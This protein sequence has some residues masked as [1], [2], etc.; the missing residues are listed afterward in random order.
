MVVQVEALLQLVG[1]LAADFLELVHDQSLA[2][3]GDVVAT[4]I[5]GWDNGLRKEVGLRRA[6]LTATLAV[7]SC[8]A[9]VTSLPAAG[10]H[11]AQRQVSQ[12]TFLGQPAWSPDGKHIAWVAGPPNG[13]GTVW[14]ADASGRNARPL[15]Q[16][17]QSLLG[18]DLVD[19]ITW[20]TSRSLLV[21]AEL[22]QQPLAL[23]RLS[24]SGRITRIAIVP[25][26]GFS[27]DRSRRL[28]ATD[29]PNCSP[30]GNCPSRIYI[31][32]LAS[33]EVTRAGS[34][35][36][37]DTWPALSPDGKRVAYRRSACHPRCGNARDIWLAPTSG[38]GKPRQ[39]ARNTVCCGQ[40]WSPDGRIIAY[41]YETPKG[42]EGLALL[43]PGHRPRKLPRFNGAGVFSPDSRLLALTR[44][45][46]NSTI[47]QLVVFD[48]RA[49]RAV[50]VSP[51]WLG[52]VGVSNEAWSP[53]GKR[54]I[55]VARPTDACT[56]LYLVTLRTKTWTPFRACG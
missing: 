48:F 12:P 21:G 17:G 27:T 46:A 49:H 16:F 29:G 42:V 33:G 54:L 8:L 41:T 31:L 2:V 24:L 19:Q 1:D 30:T 35:G 20:E 28:V 51:K 32:H 44:G 34:R 3:A 36:D 5:C 23:Y 37:L 15:H 40:T 9:A 53:D 52:N 6:G 10:A 47:G 14:V 55:V 43:R 26:L 13:Y 38:H 4:R 18:D 56:S 50:L 22:Y 39:I 25:D 11:A 45:G 7:A